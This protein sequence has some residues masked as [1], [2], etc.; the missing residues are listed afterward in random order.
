MGSLDAA[1]AGSRVRPALNLLAALLACSAWSYCSAEAL[2]LCD[3]TAP[4]GADEQDKVL[5][6]GGVIKAEL[7]N[8]GRGAALVSRSAVDLSRFGV[9]YSHAGL[10]FKT[11]RDTAWSVRQL[12]YACN[13]GRP[14]I[15]DQG[16]SGFLLGADAP[17]IA[18]VSVVLLPADEG[19]SL[20]RAA[21]DNRQALQLLGTAYSAN[22]YP[23]SVRYQNCNQWVME[24]LATSLGRLPDFEPAWDPRA[25]AQ[26]WLQQHGYVPTV[27]E[28]GQ[29]PLMWFA[30]LS[31]WLHSDDHPAEEIEAMR[32]RVSMPASI[33]AFVRA[34]V[35]GAARIEFCRTDTRVVIRYGWDPIA[36]GCQPGEHD[37]V[38]AL[39]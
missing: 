39:Q 30:T 37:T 23:F 6:F 31:P 7:E 29:R 8:S 32:Y 19:A 17:P 1:P 11:G 5:R 24:L 25:Q 26:G 22:A 18:Y 3:R 27:F 9:R 15:Y 36:E 21:M 14:R 38:V 20:Q 13:E 16:L 2:R 28:V 10:S 33:E 4:L 35:P 34:T 12:Y